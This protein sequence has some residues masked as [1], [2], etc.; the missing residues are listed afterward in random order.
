MRCSRALNPAPLPR[1]CSTHRPA[2]V[3]GDVAPRR[4]FPLHHLPNSLISRC[5]SLGGGGR[6]ECCRFFLCNEFF[7]EEPRVPSPAPSLLRAIRTPAG[8]VCWAFVFVD[9]LFSRKDSGRFRRA[10]N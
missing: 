4:I 10:R 6:I 9:A 2:D 7:G 3:C 1:T 8:F 5:R